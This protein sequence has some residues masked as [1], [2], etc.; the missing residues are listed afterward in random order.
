MMRIS[1]WSVAL[2]VKSIIVI[3][4]I[5][6][7]LLSRLSFT[8]RILPMIAAPMNRTVKRHK[9]MINLFRRYHRRLKSIIKD[10]LIDSID[11]SEIGP[12]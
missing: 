11:E 10:P 7:P 4:R 9:G 8:P 3:E 5:I 12:T 1:H 2:T 6:S